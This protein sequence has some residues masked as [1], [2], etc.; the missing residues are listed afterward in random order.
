MEFNKIEES[1][2]QYW[3]DDKV[4]EQ[5][6]T[7]RVTCPKWEFLDGPPFVNGSPHHGHLLVSTIKDTMARYM[8]QK[9]YQ[10]SYQIGFDCHGLPL[11]QE[12]EK[13]V[14]KVGPNDTQE[15]V[16]LFN[17]TCRGIIGNCSEKWYEILGQLGR[18]F[19]RDQTYYTSDF[20]YMKSLWDA[21]KTLWDKDLIY[22][23][24]KVM[25]YS[26]LCETPLSN[27]EANQN[28]KERTDISVFVR[29]KVINKCILD[30]QNEYLVVW[31]TT[32][33]SLFANQG[34]CVNAS[35]SYSLVEYENNNYWI[36]TT[37]IDRVFHPGTYK[38]IHSTIGKELTNIRYEPIFN[39]S[40]CTN[41]VYAD[42]YV[43]DK[44]GTGI[45][46]LAPLFGEDDMRVMKQN[47]YTMDML[48]AIVDSGVKFNFDYFVNGKNIAGQFVMD[49]SLDIVIHLK[50]T[51]NCIKSEKIKHNYPYCWRTDSPLVYLATDA[52]F[53]KVQDLIPDIL[54]N[55]AKIHWYPKYVGTERFANWIRTAPDWCLSRNRTWGTPIPIWISTSG[56]QM[57]I[58]D[59]EKLS[60]LSGQTI[61]DLHLD[62]IYNLSFSLDGEI[63]T[64]TFGVL[65]CWFESGLAPFA[66]ENGNIT[67]KSV[68]FIAESIDQTRGW[69]YTLNVL[70]TALY[71]QPA[72]KKVI[73]SGLI[74]A[75]DGKK[76][77]KRLGNYTNP[78]DL[79]NK[80]GSDVL[81]LYLL[82]S[83]AS[84]A[85]SFCFKD[86]DLVDITRKLI[87]YV[88]AFNILNESIKLI[89]EP[90]EGTFNSS[91]KLDIWIYN[92][93]HSFRNKVY[94]HMENLELTHIPPLIYKFI[95]QLCNTFIKLS[96]DRLKSQLTHEDAIESL[97]T[98]KY[99]LDNTNVL[100]A[101][102][103]PHL[104][105][106]FNQ[107]IHS[108]KQSIHIKTIDLAYREEPNQT[109]I[110][111]IDSL[112]ELFES[113]R[114][115][116]NK[117][118]KPN[119]Y[120]LNTLEIYTGSTSIIEFTDVIKKELNIKEI[121]IYDY[122]SLPFIYKPNR[123]ALGK[124]FK[125]KCN[126][127]FK[128]IESGDIDFPECKPEYYS[129]EYIAKPKDS[130]IEAKFDYFNELGQKQTA[131]VYLSKEVTQE[132][133]NEAHLNH[134]RRQVNVLRKE[135]NFKMSD[136]ISIRMKYNDVF[137]AINMKQLSQ[138]LGTDIEIV[139]RLGRAHDE[140][141]TLNDEY[142]IVRIYIEKIV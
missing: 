64:R 58:S 23:S 46:H 36:T 97:N 63:Y 40:I 106:Y 93:F 121:Q 1:I 110:Q 130:F 104:S 3:K 66:R 95:D 19:N 141:P 42:N 41:R 127:Y 53:L 39:T 16:K 29:F 57:C 54:E 30:H 4:Q 48:P 11:E 77:S 123:V 59:V 125:L 34:I 126:E 37:A 88:N 43:D 107:L 20:N 17:D 26:P 6:Q 21:F 129:I 9:G 128:R 52:W 117:L 5:I 50:S 124:D 94:Y 67:S 87:P 72:F 15:R 140:I 28:Y 89:D 2:R 73:V 92:I 22:C 13:L 51:G 136:K 31:T 60:K 79:M 81:R 84:K 119:I 76:M 90:I 44:T 71:N 96:R 118:N 25:P 82:S 35:L 101:P 99:V 68:D 61:T 115:L 86:K 12:A 10:I 98:L 27:F 111:S 38:I 134:I 135:Y 91:N 62:N 142:G 85:E 14:G 139:N 133:M 8:S 33:W 132:N 70:S 18:Q 108:N 100:L 114:T 138:Q 47:S 83:S 45:V 105:E 120:P 74:L 78:L 32:P 80:Y 103:V 122:N 131:V 102:F 24:K 113:V 116:R 56:K 75:E 49:T 109:I 69:F 137:N 55:N 7:S 65:D 112:N